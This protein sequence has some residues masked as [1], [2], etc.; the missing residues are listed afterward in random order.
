MKNKIPTF[1]RPSVFQR[2]FLIQRDFQKKFMISYAVAVVILILVPMAILHQNIKSAVENHLYRTHI[3]IE[4]VGDF[5]FE[6][7]FQINFYTIFSV[8]AVVLI[9]SLVL[10]Q[11]INRK[12][13]QLGLS[14]EA[15]GKGD[16]SSSYAADGS[17]SEVGNLTV[18][19]EKVR[20]VNH[21]R[22]LKLES[23]LELLEKGCSGSGDIG[24]ITKGKKD[25]DSIVKSIS[26]I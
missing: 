7:L 13:A 8:V 4:K 21:E 16:F 5:L 18:L 1:N 23:A 19:L 17:W 14:V 11:K 3:H 2:Q 24:L 26:F 25:L 10:F 20:K 22:L 15:M 12:F 9:L 6:L